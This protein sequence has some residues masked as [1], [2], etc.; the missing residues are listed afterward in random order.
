MAPVV[1]AGRCSRYPGKARM[2]SQYRRSRA[3]GSTGAFAESRLWRSHHPTTCTNMVP[4]AAAVAA[5]ALCLHLFGCGGQGA[6][7]SVTSVCFAGDIMLDR[8]VRRQ[9]H[10]LGVD[11]LFSDITPILSS[12]DFA[13]ANLECPV[14]E[15]V[16]PRDKRYVFRADPEWLPA[17]RRAGL[18]HLVLANNHA[19]DHGLEG[20]ARTIDTLSDSHIRPVGAALEPVDP[21]GPVLVPRGECVWALFAA[22]HVGRE[23]PRRASRPAATCRADPT[24][25]VGLIR[26]HRQR[27]PAGPVIVL[28]HWGVEY[29]DVPSLSQEADA[30]A[31]VDAGADAVIGHHPHV[32][33]PIEVYQDRPIFYSLGNLVFDQHQAAARASMIVRLTSSGRGIDSVEIYPLA[34]EDCI[35]RWVGRGREEGLRIQVPD[36]GAV[37]FNVRYRGMGHSG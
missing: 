13:V 10:R 14:T 12:A 35:P 28:L 32:L 23:E 27:H 8:G 37:R 16:H 24:E 1:R 18:S 22:V 21:C 33:Q 5:M 29:S 36:S 30:R 19:I 31:L 17:V 11:S 7:E 6:D 15:P 25:L 34:L 3:L 20:L 9:I 2:T 26:A 4:R